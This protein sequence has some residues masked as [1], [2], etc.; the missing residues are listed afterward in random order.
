A[1]FGSFFIFLSSSWE[2]L[3]TF[4]IN[5]VRAKT[6][7]HPFIATVAD[8]V[9]VFGIPSLPLSIFANFGEMVAYAFFMF[10]IYLFSSSLKNK[11]FIL[12]TLLCA[13]LIPF[14]HIFF[15]A[16]L[17]FGILGVFGFKII[18]NKKIDKNLIKISS[19]FIFFLTLGA[20][21]LLS[22]MGSKFITFNL[23]FNY[24][25]IFSDIQILFSHIF[26][27]GIGFIFGVVGILSKKLNTFDYLLL[28]ILITSFLIPN[29]IDFANPGITKFFL[30]FYIVWGVYAGQGFNLF[31]KTVENKKLFLF[32]VLFLALSPN[33]VYLGGNII[34]YLTELGYL[35]FTIRPWQV[36]YVYNEE[37]DAFQWI[38]DNTKSNSIL[39]TAPDDHYPAA[40]GF[41]ERSTYLDGFMEIKSGWFY[42]KANPTHKDILNNTKLPPEFVSRYSEI[43]ELYLNNKISDSMKNFN[44]KIYVLLRKEERKMFNITKLDNPLLKEIYNKNGV[45]IYE[46]GV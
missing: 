38:K 39:I 34:A 2:F 36:F 40:V 45:I 24:K 25:P 41:A 7:L 32:L 4:T 15:A 35:D 21:P 16:I 33:I 42:L 10:T 22:G 26:I 8:F 31:L 20:I 11:K 23:F 14:Y 43:R 17:F 13:F 46:L 1:I 5:L 28:S 18:F 9:M 44:R 12:P 37:L 19:L 27:L 30:F 6:F 3:Y 29:L